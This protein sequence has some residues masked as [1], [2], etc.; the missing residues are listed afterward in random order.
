MSR[1]T[2]QQAESWRAA[3][4]ALLAE[5]GVETQTTRTGALRVEGPKSSI[6]VYLTGS[7][8][9]AGPIG[10]ADYLCEPLAR[11]GLLE[12]WEPGSRGSGVAWVVPARE[13][14][15]A[16]EP[17]SG[18]TFELYPEVEPSSREDW[19]PSRR[20][21]WAP[22]DEVRVDGEGDR[23]LFVTED[24]TARSVMLVDEGG[25]AHG[26]ESWAKVRR[27]PAPLVVRWA[28]PGELRCCDRAVVVSGWEGRSAAEI[29]AALA[30]LPPPPTS[31][32]A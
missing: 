22:G 29:Q 21:D 17:T 19:A 30:A 1:R 32:G 2:Y 9:I 4:V 15:A 25:A 12:G 7:V 8:A 18:V 5:V 16:R 6:T 11:H 27:V 13:P 24:M 10:H 28:D 31:A 26:R 20:E 14:A 3:T 23:R